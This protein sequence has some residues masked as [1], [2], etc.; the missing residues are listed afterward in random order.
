MTFESDHIRL[1][2][3]ISVR[4]HRLVAEKLLADPDAV[5][6]KASDFM[7][8][9]VARSDP[10]EIP[11]IERWQ[12]LLAGPIDRLVE[13]LRS[14]DPADYGLHATCPFAGVLT[15]EERWAFYRE[16]RDASL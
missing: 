16:V 1:V 7:R 9:W 12:D 2:D 11:W 15:P 4:Q 8:R 3:E 13:V 14:D 10:L 6:A 5:M